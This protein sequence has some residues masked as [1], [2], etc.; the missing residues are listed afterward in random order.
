MYIREIHINKFRHLDNIHLGP[1]NHHPTQSDLV[2]LAGPNGSGKS[3]ILELLGYA[4]SNTWGWTWKTSRTFPSSSFELEFAITTNERE[5]ILSHLESI[6]RYYK[7]DVMDY[8]RENGTYYRA[9]NFDDG[10]YQAQSQLYDQIHTIVMEVLRDY[11]RRNLGFFLKSDRH[12]P[13]EA[14]QRDRLFEYSKMAKPEY[15]KSIAFHTSDFQYKDMLEFLI[16]QRFHYTHRLGMYEER[17]IK[18]GSGGERPQ[19]PLQQYDDL[20][21]HLF[22][23]YSFTGRN[24]EVPTNL[25]VKLPSEDEIAFTDL[26]SGEK[27][28]FFISS[29]FLRHNVTNAVNLIDEPELHLHPELARTLVS[30][31]QEVRPGN[32]IWLA[33][34]NPEIIDE[35]GTDKVYYIS[36]DPKTNSSGITP[37]TNETEALKHFKAIFGH[38]G[39]ISI[40]KSIVFLEGT[41]TSIDRK[42]F[43]KLFPEHRSQIKFVPSQS[44]DVLANIN[45]AI[46]S[47]LES[48]LGWM[49]FYLIR[50]RDYLTPETADKLMRHASGRIY[51]LFR[52]EIENYLLD[53]D[54]I[55][56][57]QTDI[58]NHSI[59]ASDVLNRMRSIVYA[60]SGEVL[61]DMVSYRLNLFYRPADF[62]LGQLLKDQAIFDLSGNPNVKN[63]QALEEHFSQRVSEV[64]NNL[65]EITS[66][67][68]LHSLIS[69]CQQEILE[70]IETD[71]CENT[72]SWKTV[73]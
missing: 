5:L 42:F 44:S 51:V 21:Q 37:A 8:L 71:G 2:V 54:T 18:S 32:Q 52:H 36:H 64:N 34:H 48:N 31:I 33:T 13:H 29:F 12:Y 16:Q 28:V 26:S 24:E 72:I 1:F 70:A 10:Q 7:K 59:A 57:I 53:E 60:M 9:F 14:F 43:T 47:I 3:S 11:Y 23:G 49:Q 66:N 63:L 15:I 41:T 69:Q 65:V 39:Y 46:L 68:N 61:R 73:A 30:T 17:R 19:D 55:A 27:E 67:F 25:F 35:A 4:L 58:Y 6:N 22:P 50:D 38:S 45:T 62:S 20:L 56:H 40:G